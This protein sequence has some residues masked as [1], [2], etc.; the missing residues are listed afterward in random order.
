[1]RRPN[2]AAYGLADRE[3]AEIRERTRTRD[4]L[5]R[6]SAMWFAAALQPRPSSGASPRPADSCE[7][8]WLAA[9]R[10]SSY[11]GS[12][13]SL[14]ASATSFR[15]ENTCPM[16]GSPATGNTRSPSGST[17]PEREGT[18]AGRTEGRSGSGREPSSANA[19]VRRLRK[20]SHRRLRPVGDAM[21]PA[22]RLRKP[23]RTRSPRLFLGRGRFTSSLRWPDRRCVGQVPAGSRPSRSGG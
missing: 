4:E 19:T 23:G 21:S 14:P 13:S 11:G 8:S 17:K 3:A 10:S 18:S 2:P 9:R 16:L 5:A 22:I 6:I 20:T 12:F 15:P 7:A 1:M